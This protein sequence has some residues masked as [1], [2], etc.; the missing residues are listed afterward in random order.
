MRVLIISDPELIPRTLVMEQATAK[1]TSLG[2]RPGMLEVIK[3]E[4]PKDARAW[5]SNPVVGL[6]MSGRSGYYIKLMG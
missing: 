5:H 4:G 2:T 6:V 3:N 1:N